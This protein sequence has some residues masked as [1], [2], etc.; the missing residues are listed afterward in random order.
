MSTSPGDSAVLAATGLSLTRS[1]GRCRAPAA[2]AS[3]GPRVRIGGRPAARQDQRERRALALA[4]PHLD[5]ASERARQPSRQSQTDAGAVVPASVAGLELVEVL[6]QLAQRRGPGSRSRCRAPRRGSRR[7]SRGRRGRPR[8][9]SVNLIAFDSRFKRICRT[10]C[11]SVLASTGESPTSDDEPQVL[12]PAKTLHLGDARA[13]EL[14]DV[15]RF[16][17]NIDP[18]GLGLREI[19]HVVDEPE[20]VLAVPRDALER[21]PRAGGQ[22]LLGDVNSRSA[23][24][25]MADSGVR[26]S[27]LIDARNSVF[28]LLARASRSPCSARATLLSRRRSCV[29]ALCSATAS[30]RA[31]SRTAS[32]VSG[33][34]NRIP[35]S[36]IAPAPSSPI[37]MG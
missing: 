16:Q 33:R 12:A 23:K 34:G 17:A 26:S 18:P 19:E 4:R 3:Q 11:A 13:R 1:P 10:R 32:V 27:W 31:A 22:L 14:R 2:H 30:W 15:D 9:A 35:A 8:P 36:T 6:E 20:Q 24:P 29:H 21:L 7:A 28:T 37:A 25:R 5:L